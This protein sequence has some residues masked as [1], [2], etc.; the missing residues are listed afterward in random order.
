MSDVLYKG[1]TLV[2]L[3][4]QA[5]QKPEDFGWWGGDEMF[6]TWGW[7]GIDV[8]NASD[9]VQIVNFDLIKKDLMEKFPDDF[10]VVG[11]RHWAVGHVDRLTCRILKNS[12]SHDS[13]TDDDITDA[14]KA[15]MDCLFNWMIILLLMM[16]LFMSIVTIR[17]WSGLLKS[18][19]LRFMLLIRK[20][21][22]RP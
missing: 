18:C 14:F 16:M 13:I 15:A 2:E 9:S 3:A 7:S 17:N 22:R 12:I 10:E 6:D 19:R 11:L 21:K 20:K 4:Q 8:H 5:L 1:L